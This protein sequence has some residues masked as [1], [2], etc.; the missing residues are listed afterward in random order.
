MKQSNHDI[1]GRLS[2]EHPTNM[3]TENTSKCL[4]GLL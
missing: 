2:I 1:N 4:L 3:K